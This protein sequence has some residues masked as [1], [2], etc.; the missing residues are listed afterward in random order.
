MIREMW[1]DGWLGRSIL[2]GIPSLLVL[3]VVAIIAD[4]NQWDEFKTKHNCKIVGKMRGDVT[5]TVA[6]IIGGNGGV[7][8]GTSVTA[9]KTG[10]LCDDGVTY[11]R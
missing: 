9:D 8:I 7:A 10:W 2:L 5:T 3:M 6:P 11:W 1:N 4:A